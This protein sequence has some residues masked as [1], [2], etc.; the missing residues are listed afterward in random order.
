MEIAFILTPIFVFVLCKNLLE[1]RAQARSERIRILEE[2]LKNPAID[3]AT[4]EQ[5]TYQLTGSRAPQRAGPGV[6]AKFMLTLGWI[7]L[8]AGIGVGIV[9]GTLRSEEVTVAGV[10]AIVLGFGFLTYPF[11]LRELEVR[12]AQ[13]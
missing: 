11:A 1:Q 10:L 4:L 8:F 7:S 12:R 3:R 6:L 5:L 2:A 9:G 13:Q